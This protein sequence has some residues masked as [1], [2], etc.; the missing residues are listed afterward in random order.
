MCGICGILNFDEKKPIDKELLQTMS[1]VMTHRGPDAHGVYISDEKFQSGV[2]NVGLGHRRL[3]IIDLATGKQPIHNEDETVW[4]VSNGEIYNFR[5]WREILLKRGHKFYT[6]SDTEVIVHLYEEE[7]GNCPQSLRGD[8]AFAI[9]DVHKQSLFLARDRLGI[10][11]LFYTI[12]RERLIFASGIKALL[13]ANIENKLNLEALDCYLT[14]L[15]IPAP[16]SIFEGINKLLPG[17]I[18]ICDR[19]GIQVK[20]YWDLNFSHLFRES[21]EFYIQ[22]IYEL[23]KEA[24][25]MRLISDVPLGVFLS[26][27]IDSSSIVGLMS[28][29]GT[30]PV[31]TFS[32]GY[33]KKEKSYNELKSARM[34]AKHFHTE[35]REYIVNPDIIKLLPEVVSHLEEPFADSSAI[36]IYLL[37][38]VAKDHIKVALTGIGGDELFAGYPRYLG[39]ELAKCYQKIPLVIRQKLILPLTEKIS[40]SS[41]SQNIGGWIKRFARGGT[42]PARERYLNWISFFDK[43]IKNKLFTETFQNELKQSQPYFRHE[44]Y[45]GRINTD[46]LLNKVFY[47]D[48]KTYL[49]DDLL[50][51][52]DRMGMANSLEIRVPFCDYKLLELSASIPYHL[53]IK[54]LNLKYLFKR[55]VSQLLPQEVIKKRKQGFMLPLAQWLRDD[56]R[57]FTESVLSEA[58]VKKRGYFKYTCIRWLLDQHYQGR[59]IFT[60]QIWA[61]LILELWHQIY[62]DKTLKV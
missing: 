25:A 2:L 6:A 57:D 20:Q 56:L 24:V 4:T 23:F 50:V 44:T 35:H 11:P 19:Q 47:L 22:K 26:G 49:A 52:A 27:G 36:L 32:I 14:F 21:E 51:M 12:N 41:K 48:V 1:R 15:Y 43:E 9:W 40:E 42:L 38:Q 45:L 34:V 55:A 33:G 37:S 60:D 53:K 5:E 62:I 13:Q 28:H 31:K 17:H 10:K 8:F 18:L 29:L 58:N 16:L 39:M 61:L 59:R 7:G 46:D 3:A 30:K 54:G